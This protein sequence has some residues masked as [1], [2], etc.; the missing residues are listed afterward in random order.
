ML[1]K[2][3]LNRNDEDSMS[4]NGLDFSSPYNNSYINET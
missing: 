2:I 3:R 4:D 1:D